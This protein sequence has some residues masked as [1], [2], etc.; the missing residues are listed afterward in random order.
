MYA[1]GPARRQ[2]QINRIN[3]TYGRDVLEKGGEGSRGGKV[4][5]HTKSGKAVYAIS[6]QSQHYEKFTAED[7]RDAIKHLNKEH[8]DNERESPD[9]KNYRNNLKEYAKHHESI[10][11]EKGKVMSE[12]AKFK[13]EDPINHASAFNGNIDDFKDE[14]YAH[15][16]VDPGEYSEVDDF[17]NSKKIKDAFDNYDK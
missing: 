16:D 10:A 11:K 12:L 8:D 4:I 6:G 13:D 14:M 2:Q 15:L 9:Q 5:G 3:V 7:H 1:N 17:I